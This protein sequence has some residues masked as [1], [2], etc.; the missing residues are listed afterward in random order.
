MAKK[1][2]R[3]T[4][5]SEERATH[6]CGQIAEGR[7]LSAICREDDV[8]TM[9]TIFRWLAD[10]RY[11]AFREMYTQARE[12][13]AETHADEITAIADEVLPDAAEVAKARLRIDARKWVAA[14]LKPRKYGDK[15]VHSGDEESPVTFVIRDMTK[16]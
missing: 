14:K 15:V 12:I 4:E 9:T 2:G 8:P 7:S 10:D 16:G 3:P 1:H 13:Q 5:Y 11:S 6:I